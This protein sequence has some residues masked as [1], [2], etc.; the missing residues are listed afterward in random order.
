[1]MHS[2]SKS[3][4]VNVNHVDDGDGTAAD[5]S[6]PTPSS[7]VKYLNIYNY[8]T[9]ESLR[10]K[11]LFSQ[12]NTKRAYSISLLK[13]LDLSASAK[14]KAGSSGILEV[15][16]EEDVASTA[17]ADVMDLQSELE[18]LMAVQR[19]KKQEL[20]RQNS[21]LPVLSLQFNT[22]K[23]RLHDGSQSGSHDYLEHHA[24][25]P[26]Q[27]VETRASFLGDNDDIREEET[28]KLKQLTK[29]GEILKLPDIFQRRLRISVSTV[30]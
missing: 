11:E 21:H 24:H 18:S 1:M 2:K 6:H 23:M 16:S 3:G 30:A 4:V 10:H 8:N 20:L 19:E 17:A 28:K 26:S 29:N 15:T 7:N 14:K 22:V 27:I 5:G 9:Q 25:D 13:P 12:P